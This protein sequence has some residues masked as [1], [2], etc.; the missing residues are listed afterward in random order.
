MAQQ[1][2]QVI[3]SSGHGYAWRKTE[4][5]NYRKRE[6]TLQAQTKYI[7]MGAR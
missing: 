5:E 6:K 7:F 4:K 3:E 2:G 1:K